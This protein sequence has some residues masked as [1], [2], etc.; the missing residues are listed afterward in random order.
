MSARIFS[1]AVQI[2][3]WP[4]DARS[5]AYGDGLFETLRVHRG[6]MP[7]WDTHWGRLALGARRLR[8]ALP[9]QAQVRDEAAAMFDDRCDGV[10]KLL[11]SR[12]GE[13]RGY[14]PSLAAAP[15]WMLSRHGLPMEAHARLQL[16][17]CDI[18]HACQPALAG[19]KHCNRLEQVLARAECLDA[20]ADEGLMLDG[21]GAVVS[22]IAANL[23]VLHGGCW[24]T[25]VL[26]QSGVAGVCRTHLIPLLGAREVRLS[27]S[28]VEG[29][30]A[31]FLCNAVRGI[32]PVA[33]LGARAWTPHSAVDAA[34]RQ[35][36]R[37]HPGFAIDVEHP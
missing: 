5:I 10:L 9:D 31:V 35:L 6:A 33:Q 30:D 32:L 26:D 29:A 11:L 3:A 8:M 36:A 14:T 22:A 16:R 34:R 25:P 12:G 15:L 2:G 19:L 1:G 7:W 18:R 13:G 28:E 27:V 24:K 20:G 4:S 21:S 37:I 17:W 23:F